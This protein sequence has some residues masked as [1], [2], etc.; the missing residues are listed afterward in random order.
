MTSEAAAVVRVALF[1]LA[2]AVASACGR[3]YSGSTCIPR[4]WELRTPNR[5]IVAGVVRDKETEEPI[6]GV[7]VRLYCICFRGPL[8]AKTNSNGVYQFDRLAP[9]EYAIQAELGGERPISP[10]WVTLDGEV[11][12]RADFWTE[13]PFIREPSSPW[14]IRRENRRADPMRGARRTSG[15]PACP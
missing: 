11:A 14:Q 3:S 10:K 2:L 12:F 7:T 6:G 13:R 15:R 1:A 8:V 9:G 5:S 4:N